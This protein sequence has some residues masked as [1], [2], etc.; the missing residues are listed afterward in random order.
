MAYA[1]SRDGAMPFSAFWHKVNENEVPLNAVWV[2]AIIAFCM[3]LT[4]YTHFQT[5]NHPSCFQPHF[6]TVL[7]SAVTGKLSSVSSDGIHS[8]HRT[9]HRICSADLLQSDSG[10]EVFQTGAIHLGEV[11]SGRWMDCGPVGGN[12]LSALLVASGVSNHERE[13]ELH[14]SCSWRAADSNNWFMDVKR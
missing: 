7:I 4:V 13:T 10:S 2:S 8:H 11:W 3:A 14:S 5:Q 9:L 6:N 1:F 12:D